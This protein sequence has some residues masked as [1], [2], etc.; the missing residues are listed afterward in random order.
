MP[1]S[2]CYARAQW[3]ALAQTEVAAHSTNH[4]DNDHDTMPAEMD[5]SQGQR[6]RFFKPGL[7]LNLPVYLDAP[8]QARLAALAKARG[9]EFSAFINELLKKDIERLDLAR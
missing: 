1:S 9:R 6:G 4:D 7:R 5:L 3:Q 2:L 8:V